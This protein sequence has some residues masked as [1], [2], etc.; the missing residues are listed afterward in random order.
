M[1]DRA[2]HAWQRLTEIGARR[3][4]AR[5]LVIE[6]LAAAP[7]HLSAADIH[8]RIASVRPE[9]NL[10]TVY[11]TTSFLV[12]Q[13]IAHL[14]EWPGEAMYGLNDHPHVHAVCD[15]CGAHSEIPAARLDGVLAEARRC[16]DLGLQ[17]AGMALFGRCHDCT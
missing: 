4:Q 5:A 3:T 8:R 10:T 2:G 17:P 7:G 1:S 11:R 9:V 13:G 6:V 16:G 14:L 12:G 15:R